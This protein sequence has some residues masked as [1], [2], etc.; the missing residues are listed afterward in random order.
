MGIV[1]FVSI[2]TIN[3]CPKY[4]GPETCVCFCILYFRE[5][6]TQTKHVMSAASS[7]RKCVLQRV[8]MGLQ[9]D[10]WV[11]SFE[12]GEKEGGR[13]GIGEGA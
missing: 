3:Q 4:F 7:S 5:T 13:L 10:S 8:W 11:R 6:V 1:A 2:A 9:S 12:L